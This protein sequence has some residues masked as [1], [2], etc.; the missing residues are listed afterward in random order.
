M[1]V[2]S[3]FRLLVGNID[4]KHQFNELSLTVLCLINELVTLIYL[5]MLPLCWQLGG[6]DKFARY[7]YAFVHSFCQKKLPWPSYRPFQARCK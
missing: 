6:K 2:E 7:L 1:R 5:L 4:A 3:L